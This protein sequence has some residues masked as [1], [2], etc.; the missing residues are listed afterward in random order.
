MAAAA[1]VVVVHRERPNRS[2]SFLHILGLGVY[3]YNSI[4]QSSLLHKNVPPLE[5]CCGLITREG[6]LPSA[7]AASFAE[8]EG[9]S[10]CET[11][12]QYIR[13]LAHSQF[14][15][16]G[17]TFAGFYKPLYCPALHVNLTK[18]FSL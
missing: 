2:F 9:K 12:A 5:V 16:G 13:L 11:S 4:F 15:T 10:A 14:S 6:P 7:A 3:V 8:S 1:V 18:E 17:L